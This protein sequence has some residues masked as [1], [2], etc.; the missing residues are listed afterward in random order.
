[1]KDNL[2]VRGVAG[3]TQIGWKAGTSDAVFEL[4]GDYDHSGVIDTADYLIWQAQN[5]S[6]GAVGQ[7]SA[8]GNDNGV[9]DSA[10]YS[11][12]SANYGHT[13]QLFDVSA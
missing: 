13:L 1:V 7:F 3:A 9:V 5:G 6:A 2:A 11:V 10:D 8:D 12:W 4:L